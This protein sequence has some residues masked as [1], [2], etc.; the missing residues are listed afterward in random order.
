MM[1]LAVLLILVQA[2]PVTDG[3]SGEV[4]ASAS[5]DKNGAL[6]IR[7][8]D[9]V[10]VAVYKRRDQTRFETPRLS[11]DRRAVGAQAMYP[12]CC[13][14]YDIPLG[15]VVY[16]NGREHWFKGIGL[17]IF[18]WMFADEGRRIAYGQSTVHSSCGTHYELRDIRT[19]RLI[20]SVLVPD[21]FP[22]CP[23]AKPV[24]IPAWVQR[25]RDAPVR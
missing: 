5:V 24:R 7:R 17:S 4:Y 13:T 1:S 14:S 8:A 20:E 2:A 22:S 10:T 15:L 21:D 9:G 6:A 3:Q 25:L 16:E 18:W 11:R 12:N 23:P 19:E